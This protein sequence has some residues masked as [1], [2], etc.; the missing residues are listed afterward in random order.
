MMQEIL[1]AVTYLAVWFVCGVVIGIESGLPKI[2][3][4]LGSAVSVYIFIAV[5]E[6]KES[7]KKYKSSPYQARAKF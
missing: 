2:F 6:R 3:V 1:T 7:F 5:K 4:S